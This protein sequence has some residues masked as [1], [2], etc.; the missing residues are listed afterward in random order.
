MEVILKEDVKGLGYKNDIV[1]VKP[2]YGRNY[3]IPQGLAAL[4]TP[5]AKKMLA[6]NLKQAAHKAEKIKTAALDLANKL[7]TVRV[8]LPAKV[9]E[10]GKIF[11]AITTIQLADAL[12]AQGF[13]LDRRKISINEKEIKALGEYSATIDLHREVKQQVTFVVIEG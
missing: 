4:A 5:A 11:G 8:E 7:A 12:K 9:S 1:D 13:D 6:E 10:T 3:L 2:G